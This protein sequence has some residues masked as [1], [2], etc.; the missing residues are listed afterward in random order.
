MS[1]I[2]ESMFGLFDEDPDKPEDVSDTAN[3]E[4]KSSRL[5]AYFVDDFQGIFCAYFIVA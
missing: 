1:D 3:K 2:M 4:K 5:V